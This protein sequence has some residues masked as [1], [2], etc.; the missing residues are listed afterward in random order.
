MDLEVIETKAVTKVNW[1]PRTFEQGMELAKLVANTGFAP[2]NY[3]GHP[4]ECL[5]AMMAG[6]EVGL[7][8][9]ASLQNIAVINGYPSVFGDAALALV[10][11]S[12]DYEYLHETFSEDGSTAICQAKRKGEEE[13]IRKFSLKDAADAGLLDKPGPWKQYRKR[14]LQMRARAWAIR[15]VWPHVLKGL[16][17]KEEVQDI[18]EPKNVTPE[19]K[20]EEL[21]KNPVDVQIERLEGILDIAVQD[22]KL[23]EEESIKTVKTVREKY[24]TI[25]VLTR[26]IDKIDESL[27]NTIEGDAE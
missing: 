2:K 12:P 14:M 10:K 17:I 25:D 9:M 20:P 6:N 15:D 16:S 4:E 5:M 23:T 11:A 3:K 13:S 18:K 26:R 1:A 7:G 24:K 8:P 22:E 21:K 19:A 27:N